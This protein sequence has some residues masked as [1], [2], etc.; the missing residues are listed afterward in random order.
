M[1]PEERTR[2]KSEHDAHIPQ[3]AVFQTTCTKP[4]QQWRDIHV[5]IQQGIQPS[6]KPTPNR[7]EP[8]RACTAA[9]RR[10]RNRKTSKCFHAEFAI[11]QPS[12]V[13]TISYFEC[14]ANFAM[15][16]AIARLE[17][18]HTG[19]DQP[20]SE[21]A[22]INEMARTVNIADS[23]LSTSTKFSLSVSVSCVVSAHGPRAKRM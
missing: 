16:R 2:V 20:A 14:F 13:D 10:K 11:M 5:C 6:V 1:R 9:Q 23:V 15:Y 8:T 21:D 18:M 7:Q 3:L 19:F 22:E 17:S 4:Q 12:N